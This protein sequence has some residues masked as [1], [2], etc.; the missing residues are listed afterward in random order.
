MHVISRKV[1]RQFWQEYPDSETALIRWLKI[2]ESVSFQSF[3]ELRSVFPNADLVTNLIVFN[4]GGNKYRL[5]ASIHF[6]LQKVYI[7]YILTHSEYDKDR[8]KS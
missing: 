7:R 6:N 2:I 5:I 4:I 1:L 3:E 8:W